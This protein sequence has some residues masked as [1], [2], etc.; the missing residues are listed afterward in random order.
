[1]NLGLAAAVLGFAPFISYWLQ[2]LFSKKSGQLQSFN[3]HWTCRYSDWIFVPFNAIFPF[4]VSAQP[5]LFPLAFL[6]GLAGS[7]AIHISWA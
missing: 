7:F 2:W 5:V 1:M 3:R 6:I 4:S